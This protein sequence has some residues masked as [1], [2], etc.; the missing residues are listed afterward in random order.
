MST[1]KPQRIGRSFALLDQA[2]RERLAV[3]LRPLPWVDGLVTAV[4]LQ[5]AAR[6]IPDMRST[7]RNGCTISGARR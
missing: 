3:L 5:L 4:V 2:T 1:R 7:R 6:T